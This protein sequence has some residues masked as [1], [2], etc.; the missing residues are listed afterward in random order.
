MH[1]RSK[2]KGAHKRNLAT[3]RST[4]SAAHRTSRAHQRADISSVIGKGGY[5]LTRRILGDADPGIIPR[6]ALGYSAPNQ[7][8][9]AP[10]APWLAQEMLFHLPKPQSHHISRRYAGMPEPQM[11]RQHGCMTST[12]YSLLCS[13]FLEIGSPSRQAPVQRQQWSVTMEV[14]TT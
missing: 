9:A 13:K 6:A 11:T 4:R 5:C 12:S 8:E 10:R 3:Y 1:K 14:E 7:P 2:V